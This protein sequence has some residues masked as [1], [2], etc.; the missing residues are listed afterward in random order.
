MKEIRIAVPLLPSE[1]LRHG[2]LIKCLLQ[3]WDRVQARSQ[4]SQPQANTTT[5][6]HSSL[7]KEGWD[8]AR[9]NDLCMCLCVFVYGYTSFTD[10]RLPDTITNKEINSV[11]IQESRSHF[12]YL[13]FKGQRWA[14][15][16]AL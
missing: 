12:S 3:I 16:N 11:F 7:W 5:V 4:L 10:R 1:K 8:L 2:A 6:A 13:E 9:T 15:G 14:Q